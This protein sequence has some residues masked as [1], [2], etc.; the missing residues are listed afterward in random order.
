VKLGLV[1]DIHGNS[2][3]LRA[4]IS[5]AQAVG[6]THWWVLGDL[7]ALGPDPVGVLECLHG[8]DNVRALAGN[9]ERYVLR[10]DRPHPT[11]DEAAGDA[12]L[13]ARLAE[14]ASSF[15]WTRGAVTQAGWFEW[16]DAL[17]GQLRM[18][19]PDGSRVLGVH[20]SP[21]ADDGAGID[22]RISDHDLAE[23]L[24]GC[25]ADLVFGGHTHDATDRSVGGIRAVNLGSV[26]NSH[27]PDRAA[28]YAILDVSADRHTVVHRVVR[29]ELGLALRAIHDAHHPAAG[30]LQQFFTVG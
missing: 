5:D 15:A 8:L 14:V 7:V 27:R 19:L 26:S 6:V 1:S 17:P 29:Y 13:I 21:S 3:A 9:T 24:R 4:V 18:T 25:N 10:G 2:I 16:L 30:F 11:V 28:T 20:A 22:N 23:L 12:G